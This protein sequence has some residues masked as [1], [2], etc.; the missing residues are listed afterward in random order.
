[1]YNIAIVTEGQW[2]G[3]IPRD[4]PNMRT[5]LAWMVALDAIHLPIDKRLADE[6][7]I[8]PFDVVIAILSKK[9]VVHDLSYWHSVSKRVVVMQEGPN[10]NW[11]DLPIDQQVEHYN[12]LV[13]ADAIF[14]HNAADVA[15]YNGLTSRPTYRMKSLIIEDAIPTSS[16]PE[17]DGVVVGGNMCSWYGGFDSMVVARRFNSKVYVPS[18]GRKQDGE[19]VLWENAEYLPYLRWDGWMSFL[20]GCKY[21]VHMMRTHAAGTFALNCGYYGIPCIGYRGL[22]TQTDIF[23]ELSVEVGD[24]KTANQLAVKLYTDVNYYNYIS[25][26]AKRRYAIHY[27]ETI[28]VTEMN[29]IIKE[30]IG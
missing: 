30:I 8:T 9:P 6:L 13:S 19:E 12:M 1:M 11:Q 7:D 18:M 4:H 21:A 27:P 24:L 20:G 22:D 29:S 17:R 26:S 2:I 23:P 15:Y 10:W 16:P 14:A 25:E 28:F 5:D 3:K